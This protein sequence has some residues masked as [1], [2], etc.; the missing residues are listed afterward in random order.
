MAVKY[1]REFPRVPGIDEIDRN[2]VVALRKARDQWAR[3]R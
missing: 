3:D 2:D 1:P